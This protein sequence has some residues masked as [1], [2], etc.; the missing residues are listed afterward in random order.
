GRNRLVFNASSQIDRARASLR[1]MIVRLGE[2]ATVG[3]QDPREVLAPVVA[4]ALDARRVAREERAFAVADALRDGLAAAGVEVRD[5]ADG[6]EW[7]LS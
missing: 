7:H 2:V 5:T 3:L 1:S 4:A 6:V